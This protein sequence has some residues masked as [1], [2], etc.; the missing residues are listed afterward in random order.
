M[1][2]E[3]S[4]EKKRET[5]KPRR[6]SAAGGLYHLDELHGDLVHPIHDGLVDDPKAALSQPA[7]AAA[8]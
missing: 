3:K 6:A 5:K 8:G 7:L 4:E 2:A 1:R